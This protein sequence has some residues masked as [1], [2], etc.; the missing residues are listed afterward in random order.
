MIYDSNQH[1]PKPSLHNC[2]QKTTQAVGGLPIKGALP[3]CCYPYV[4]LVGWTREDQQGSRAAPN[5]YRRR[6]RKRRKRRRNGREGV[7]HSERHCQY[8][9]SYRQSRALRCSLP[10]Y[11]LQLCYLLAVA[12]PTRFILQPSNSP[13][14]LCSI[15]PTARW[16]NHSLNGTGWLT[17]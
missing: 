11:G 5:R 13:T 3:G 12:P 2:I 17:G 9:R 8:T 15:S 4:L 7:R 6:R 10:A 14:G 16:P 1:L